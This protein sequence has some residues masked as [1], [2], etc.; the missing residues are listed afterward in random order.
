MNGIDLSQGAGFTE[1]ERFQNHFSHYKIV[2]YE[3]LKC[4]NIMYKARVK[5]S[6]RMNLPY[7]DV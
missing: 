5:S 1:I 4:D 3:G 7:D 6:T 2:V